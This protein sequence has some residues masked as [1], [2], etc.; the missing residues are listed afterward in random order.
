MLADHVTVERRYQRSINIELDAMSDEAFEGYI[1]PQSAKTVLMSMAEQIKQ[2]GQGSYTW[3]GPYGSGKSSLALVLA[4]LICQAKKDRNKLAKIL[5][6]DWASDLWK[7]LDLNPEGWRFVPVVG[8]NAPIYEL[9][10]RKLK[11]RGFLG[12][13]VSLTAEAVLAGLERALGANFPPT[14]LF[15]DEMGKTLENAVQSDGD[16]YFFQGLAELANRNS[17]RLVI[18]GVLHQAF[19]EYANSLSRNAKEEWAKIQGRYIDLAVDIKA[20][21]QIQLIS[22]AIVSDKKINGD[23][24]SLCEK[25]AKEIGQGK[26]GFG[27]TMPD[28]LT[29]AWPLHPAVTVG[30]GPMSRKGSGQNYR[31]VF[32]FLNSAEPGGFQEFLRHAETKDTFGILKLWDYL[33]L[34]HKGALLASS[35]GHKW[36]IALDA[37]ERADAAGLSFEAI[38]SLKTITILDWLKDGSGLGPNTTSI[39]MCLSIPQKDIKNALKKL[40]AES[41]ITFKQYLGYYGLFDGSDFN[42]DEALQLAKSEADNTNS[43]DIAEQVNLPTIIAKRHY[44]HTGTLR[45]AKFTIAAVSQIPDVI[46]QNKNAQT[47]MALGLIYFR[48]EAQTNELVETAIHNARQTAKEHFELLSAEITLSNELKSLFED[49][50]LLGHILRNK[51]ELAGDRIARREVRER[52]AHATELANDRFYDHLDSLKFKDSS[53]SEFDDHWSNIARFIDEVAT[54]RYSKSPRINN[55][56]LN[57][58]RPSAQA[59]LAL[60]KLLYALI[61]SDGEENLGFQSYPAE[62]GLFDALMISSELYKKVDGDWRIAAPGKASA[63]TLKNLWD[64]T[65]KFLKKQDGNVINLNTIYE[66]WQKPPYGLTKGVSPLFAFLFIKTNWDDLALYRQGLFR[67]EIAEIDID[68]LLK[69]PDLIDLRRM[70]VTEE[71]KA[72]LSELTDIA[73]SY[74]GEEQLIHSSTIDVAKA[75]IRSFDRLHPY[76]MRTQQVSKNARNVRSLFKNAHDPNKFLLEDIPKLNIKSTN[77]QSATDIAANLKS[78][79]DELFN[80]HENAIGRLRT[81]VLDELEVPNNSPGALSELAERAKNI[82]GLSESHV[83]EAFINRM[84]I[85]D[86][87]T[88]QMDNIVGLAAGK[89]TNVWI[90]ADAKKAELKLSEFARE[91]KH[92]E[93]F[94]HIKGRKNK[95]SNMALVVDMNAEAGPVEVQFHV[96]DSNHNNIDAAAADLLAKLSN[97]TKGQQDLMLAILAKASEKLIEEKLDKEPKRAS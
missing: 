39:A 4:G 93:T 57:R 96:L 5:K 45:W 56:L 11:D 79:L 23:F 34:S 6:I 92:L 74:D 12:K 95:R 24:K 43:L 68:V 89:P 70:E 37:V 90:D 31:S 28:I 77:T 40:E 49:I 19:Q 16:I 65:S 3:T 22:E 94:A 63:P 61:N 17:E 69:S 27:E 32:S 72:L 47:G 62:R 33:I 1:F 83:V 10:G 64:A 76:A 9:L 50:K 15:I 78:G 35:D 29:N 73:I 84:A 18:V 71:T 41:L 82:A 80:A 51:K 75:L 30:L 20:D 86:G 88:E 67:S 48:D 97:D 66:F 2:S 14:L 42:I 52:I 8:S 7:I 55:E 58:E 54:R 25:I 26:K 21:E 44:H 81:L 46:E 87:T 13:S 91:F 85:Y 38:A 53:G 59:N 60:K 36:A